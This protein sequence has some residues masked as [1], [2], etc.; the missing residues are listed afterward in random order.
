MRHGVRLWLLPLGGGGGGVYSLNEFYL[1]RDALH[2]RQA[3]IRYNAQT[4]AFQIDDNPH[5]PAVS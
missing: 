5:Q 1:Q 4:H 2:S 3:A